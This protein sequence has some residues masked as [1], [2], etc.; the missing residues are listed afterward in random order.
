MK[1]LVPQD[2]DWKHIL[3]PDVSSRRSNA[4]ADNDATGERL[5]S[6]LGRPSPRPTESESDHLHPSS[7]W[8]GLKV[9][10]G[11]RAEETGIEQEHMDG[12]APVSSS[13][14][15]RP[16]LR[17]HV[18]SKTRILVDECSQSYLR[19]FCTY[20]RC[21]V[22]RRNAVSSCSR[23]LR[24]AIATSTPTVLAPL[25][26]VRLQYPTTNVRE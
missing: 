25:T 14:N 6:S 20:Y 7:L 17:G 24:A 15:L 8:V 22:T 16:R 26:R 4:G 9:G 12:P 13:H 5:T 3:R 21:K 23:S 19:Q 10:Y 1:S 18:T 11:E 2:V